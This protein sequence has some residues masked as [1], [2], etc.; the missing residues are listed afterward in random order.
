[1]TDEEGLPGLSLQAWLDISEMSYS[2]FARL[3]PCSI[4]YPR[5]IAQ[6]LVVPSYRMATRIEKVTGGEVPRTRWY[7]SGP[8]SPKDGD[9]L[10]SEENLK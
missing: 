4:S 9:D 10:V 2:A 3:I 6:G 5:M 8:T 7:P 1:M